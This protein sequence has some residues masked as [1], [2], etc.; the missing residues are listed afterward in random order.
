LGGIDDASVTS[1]DLDGWAAFTRSRFQRHLLPGGHFFI[2]DS[3][4]AVLARLREG[5]SSALAFSGGAA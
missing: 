5:L 3:P 1:A 2:R 4:A